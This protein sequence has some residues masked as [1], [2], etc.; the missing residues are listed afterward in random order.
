[1]W[2][3]LASLVIGLL[4][5]HVGTMGVSSAR[6]AAALVLLVVF[7]ALGAFASVQLWRLRESGRK[8]AI[9]VCLVGFAFVFAQFRSLS[10]PDIVRL[11]VTGVVMLVLL[12]PSAKRACVP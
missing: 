2:F 11:I 9:G 1:M 12:S 10:G 6:A 5:L 3:G 7:V 8:A 4:L